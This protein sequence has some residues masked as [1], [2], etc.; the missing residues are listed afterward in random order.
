MSSSIP[1]HRLVGVLSYLTLILFL[2]T[3]SQASALLPDSGDSVTMP[4]VIEL[5][6]EG[7]DDTAIEYRAS[8]RSMPIILEER[9]TS[10]SSSGNTS[11]P[12]AF[13]TIGNNFTAT[14]CPKFFEYFLADETYKSCFAISILLQ[15]SNTFFKD[16]A[17]AVTLDQVLDTSCS[18][19]TTACATFMNNL[20]ANLTST[21]N[22][23]AD[24]KLGNPTVTQAYDGMVSYEP[25]AKAACLEDPSTH[26]YCFT[27]AATN[28]TN[29]SSYA[30]Y[31]LPLG[32]SL[33][34]GSRP[35]CNQCT[36]AT[37]AVFKD[38]ALIKGNPLVQTYIPAAQT[39]NVGCGPGFVNATVNVG[40]QTSTSSSKSS[41]GC[42]NATPPPPWAFA[43]FL[44]ANV[45]L[46][47]SM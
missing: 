37:M 20:A 12:T 6:H 2:I 24:Y 32:N 5:R 7:N 18:V 29:I 47:A 35:Q 33:P 31:L 25:I 36:Q 27:E 14:S 9:S 43:G 19:N 42:P 41:A 34:G 40:S 16:L 39:I 22:C 21:D 11:F 28:S 4:E 44:V 30:L 45:M 38:S 17:S 8:T 26:E 3:N 23:G 15:N 13:D 46:L 10:A 1:D